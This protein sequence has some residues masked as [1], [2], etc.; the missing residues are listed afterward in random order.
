MAG[1]GWVGSWGW[2]IKLEKTNRLSLKNSWFFVVGMNNLAKGGD[3][4]QGFLK[5]HR[6]MVISFLFVKFTL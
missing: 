6:L 1:V 5:H 2:Q 3:L 4:L